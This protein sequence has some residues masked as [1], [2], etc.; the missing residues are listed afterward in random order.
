[1]P[2]C[3]GKLHKHTN[4]HTNTDMLSPSLKVPGSSKKEC[5]KLYHLQLSG[6]D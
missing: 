5:Y 1:M 3:E 6:I 2:G 4:P